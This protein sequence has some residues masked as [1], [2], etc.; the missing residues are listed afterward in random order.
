MPGRIWSEKERAS[1][2]HQ[3]LTLGMRCGEVALRGRTSGAV[4]HQI[5]AL[6]KQGLLPESPD[7]HYHS[8]EEQVLVTLIQEGQKL[9]EIQIAGQSQQSIYGHIKLLRR[10]GSPELTLKRLWT[11]AEDGQLL[12][13][14]STLG[15]SPNEVVIE[16]CPWRINKP[17]AL[18]GFDSMP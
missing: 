13:Q 1:V 8:E 3:V 15:R 2:I 4:Y 10:R 9:S 7:R 16:T 12:R 14:V 6:R 18:L 17:M 5:Q 11:A